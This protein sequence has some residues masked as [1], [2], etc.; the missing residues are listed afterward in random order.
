MKTSHAKQLKQCLLDQSHLLIHDGMGP[1][2]E[3][4]LFQL[5]TLRIFGGVSDGG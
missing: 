2:F 1:I 4:E 3:T 5:P